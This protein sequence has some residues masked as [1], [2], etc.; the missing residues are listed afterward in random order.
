MDNFFT[1]NG[2][3]IETF[4]SVSGILTDKFEAMFIIA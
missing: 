4:L 3:K 1:E 2:N